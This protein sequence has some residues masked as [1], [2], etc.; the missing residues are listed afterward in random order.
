VFKGKDIHFSARDELIVFTNLA[1]LGVRYDRELDNFVLC[2]TFILEV[3]SERNS[4]LSFKVT[5]KV[6][7]LLGIWNAAILGHGGKS[8]SFTFRVLANPH[9]RTDESPVFVGHKCDF[10][11][12]VNNGDTD[13][14]GLHGLHV[15]ASHN[16]VAS[17]GYSRVQVHFCDSIADF[18]S[19]SFCDFAVA[20]NGEI[21]P[22]HPC[23]P[24]ADLVLISECLDLRAFD[25]LAIGSNLCHFDK[26][27]HG[28]IV[29][30]TLGTELRFKVSWE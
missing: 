20:G 28:E 27:N 18:G 8:T 19:N 2:N 26:G 7:E 4:L 21:E 25:R 17:R 23:L 22:S 1:N 13:F 11:L 6:L 24:I 15:P 10:Q 12:L 16:G 5:G 9:L 3:N 30:S 29:D 14:S